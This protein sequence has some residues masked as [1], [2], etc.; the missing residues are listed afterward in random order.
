MNLFTFLPIVHEKIQKVQYG[1]T[2]Q[3]FLYIE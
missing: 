2:P 3:L 1:V